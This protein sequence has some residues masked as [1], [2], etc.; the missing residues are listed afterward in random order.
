MLKQRLLTAL[1]AIPVV[2]IVV[3]FAPH[4]VIGGVF[5]FLVL[6]GAWEWA[7]LA[8]YGDPGIKWSIVL[9]VAVALAVCGLASRLAGFSFIVVTVGGL[10][11]LLTGAAVIAYGLGYARPRINRLPGWGVALCGFLTL[12]PAWVAVVALHGATR[13]AAY[14]FF[15]LVLIWIV[16]SGAYAAG[17]LWGH[18]RLATAI[19]PGKT[20]EGVGGG[21]LAAAIVGVCGGFFFGQ[22]LLV[23]VPVCLLTAIFSI[24]GDLN[25]S[26]FKRLAG[27]K[28]SGRIFPGHGGVLDRVDSLTAAAPVFV[29]CVLFFGF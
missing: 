4:S 22:P 20:W 27:V 5:A 17:R 15:M 26:L 8:G 14:L 10:W 25:E 1:V 18:R 29:F 2:A 28:D 11:W 3:L 7:A 21:L 12:V 23:F 6:A 9:V 24:I 19:S 16:D 13:G